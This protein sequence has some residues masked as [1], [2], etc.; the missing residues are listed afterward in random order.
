LNQRS[1][2]L[3]TLVGAV[4]AALP[5]Q[6][7]GAAGLMPAAS[8]EK[9]AVARS[10]QPI[11]IIFNHRAHRNAGDH[12]RYPD[13]PGQ[14]LKAA[15]ATKPELDS[16]LAFFAA[17]E[18]GTLVIDGGDGTVSDI[19]SRLPR[20]FGDRLPRLAIVPSGKTNALALDLGIPAKWTM[21]D[22]LQAHAAGRVLQRTPLELRYDG[23]AEA[24]LRGFLFGAGAFVRATALAQNVHKSG[25]FHGLAIALSLAGAVGQTLFGSRHNIWRRGEPMV[26]DLPGGCHVERNLYLLLGSTLERLPL[27]LK[28]FGRVRSGLKLLGIEAPPRKLALGVPMLLAGLENDW[29]DSNGYHRADVDRFHVEVGPHFVLDGEV[30]EGGR[31]TIGRGAPIDFL[32]PPA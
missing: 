21:R 16:T 5:V 25:A 11:G 29:L 2:P 27:G 6:N 17:K 10:D 13:T 19:L 7:R 15:P 9:P 3:N 32:V 28:P 26:V 30:H 4:G 20:H 1:T 24:Q 22:A 12:R 8:K 18:L 31:I 23:Q 14:V